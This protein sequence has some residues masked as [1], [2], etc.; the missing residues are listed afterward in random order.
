MA[1]LTLYLS[2]HAE[3]RGSYI[4]LILA[5]D[6]A[7]IVQALAE[8]TAFG[9]GVYRSLFDDLAAALYRAHHYSAAGR[10]LW[11]AWVRT[12]AP[13]AVYHAS[14]NV[15][16]DAATDLAPVLV[17]VADMAAQMTEVYDA[18][19]PEPPDPPL[20]IIPPSTDPA[21]TTGHA[22]MYNPAA[23][24][25]PGAVLSV[26]LAKPPA[27]YGGVYDTETRSI[28]ADGSG[29]A[30]VPGLLKGGR[31]LFYRGK[32]TTTE[33]LVPSGAGTTWEIPNIAGADA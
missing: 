1:T 22:I 17:A 12:V 13:D 9:S 7:Q 30:V 18:I 27:G 25:E 8:E 20:V 11:V 23:V 32:K 28:V 16:S 4:E 15:P 14:D 10:L 29:V 26:K 24:I 21:T 33:T 19:F 6:P 5:S 2:S 31:Y 3:H